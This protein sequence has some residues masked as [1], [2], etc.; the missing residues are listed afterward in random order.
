M[1]VREVEIMDE[2]K[3]KAAIEKLYAINAEI[4]LHNIALKKPMREKDIESLNKSLGNVIRELR[5]AVDDP[6]L[7]PL[8]RH[9]KHDWVND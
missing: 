1:Y 8:L 3:I 6:L 4:S 2:P 9:D 5:I 7:D